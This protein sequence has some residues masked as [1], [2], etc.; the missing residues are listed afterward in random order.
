MGNYKIRVK[1]EIVECNEAVDSVPKENQDG[2]FEFKISE[3][4]AISIDRCEKA[5]L[6]TN[7]EAVRDAISRHLTEASKKTQG[8]G[9]E[10]ELIANRH[11]YQVD[12]EVGR[13]EF[14]TH[15][16]VKDGGIKFNTARCVFPE[17]KGKEWY[18]TSGFKEIAIVYGATEDSYRKTERMINRIRYQEG[19]TPMRTLRDNTESEGAKILDLQG[20]KAEKILEGN[21][22]SEEGIP[23]GKSDKYSEMEGAIL[24][25]EEVA[26]AI[27]KVCEASPGEVADMRK[28]P[29]CY[30]DPEQTVNISVDDVGVKKQK[31]ERKSK[32]YEGND[33]ANRYIHNTVMHVQKGKMVYILNGYGTV[34][35]LR[36]LIAFLLYNDLL[37][38][39]LQFFVDGQRTLQAAILKAFSWYRN[40]GLILDWY[41]LE[42]KSKMQLSM[43]MKGR[44]IRNRVLKE[45]THLLWYGLVDKAIEFLRGIDNGSIK[46]KEELERLVDYLERSKPY[47][48]CYAARKELGLRNSSN[49]GEK[50]NDLVVSNRQKHNGM[51][52]S[53]PGSVA[54]ASVTAL[55]RNKEYQKWF[56]EGD[57]EFKLAA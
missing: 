55:V 7:H 50:M 26:K 10:G 38:Y 28:N 56:E 27:G 40:I 21:R 52:W 5:L 41:H 23:N 49:I 18:R 48:P 46:S 9:I 29:V 30:E 45:L 8:Q 20:R 13:F 1:V 34:N 44:D 17:L 57:I 32:E 37:G 54:L 35:V 16:L 12:G 14:T 19:A 4:E 15:S 22:F 24:P 6:R 3:A 2:S 36:I 42:K 51:S 25:E 53:R 43:A 33:G 31:E 11:P 47:V 39:R